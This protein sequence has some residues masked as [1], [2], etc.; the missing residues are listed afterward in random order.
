MGIGIGCD[1][2][3]TFTDLILL[4]EKTGKIEIQKVLTTP[5]D[6]SEGIETGLKHFEES[7]PKSISYSDILVHGTTLVINAVIERKGALTG[8]I[9]TKG[10]RDVLEIGRE[11]RYDG[12]DLQIRFPEPLVARSLRVEVHERMHVSG[13][14]L[15]PLEPNSVERALRN[16]LQQ[17]VE[18]IAVCLLNSYAN[19]AHEREVAQIVQ[20]IAPH[21]PVSLSSDVLREFKEY[22]RTTT[23]V[24]N[25]YATPVVSA[26]LSRFADRLRSLGFDGEL[27]MMQSSGGLGSLEA[28]RRS[29]VQIIESGPAAGVI[30]AAYYAGLTGHKTVL[31][32]DM[33]GTT[34][35]MCLVQDGRVAQNAELEIDRVH[36]FKLGSGIP[37]RIPVVDL[38]EIGAGGGSIAKVSPRGTLEVG[39]ESA[40]AFPG[41]ACYGLGGTE[42]TVSDADLVLGYLNPDYFLGSK[43]RLDRDR[44]GEAIDAGVAKPLGLSRSEAAWGIHSVVNETMASASK[45]YLAE[46]GHSPSS[47]AVVAFGGAGPVHACDLAARI[48][49]RTVVIPPRAGV[50]SA[51][52]MLISPMTRDK[53]LTYPTRTSQA[54]AIS[55]EERFRAMEQEAESELPRGADKSALRFERGLDMRYVGQG[56]ELLVP[57]RGI[58]ADGTLAASLRSAFNEIYRRLYGRVFDELELEITNLR[59]KATVPGRRFSEKDPVRTACASA[60]PALERLAY[61]PQARDFVTHKVFRRD[62][63]VAG[64]EIKG[65]AI[66]E[67]AESTTIVGANGS[68]SLHGSGAL[69]VALEPVRPAEFPALAGQ[70][71]PVSLEMLWRRLS[72]SVDELSA[73]LVCTSFSS[74]VRDVKDYACAIFDA[75]GRLIVQSTDSTPGIGGGL[76]PM[77]QHMLDKYPPE[78]LESGDVLIGNHPWY[79][80]GHHNDIFVVTPA[81]HGSTLI[82]FATCAAHH[83]DIGGRRST[84]ESRDNYEEGLKIPVSKFFRAGVPNEDIFNFI[85]ANVRLCDTVIGDLRAQLA[86]NHVACDRL[87][88]LCEERGWSDLQML[89]DV[90]VQRSRQITEAEIAKIPDGVYRHEAPIA[91]V[92]GDEIRLRVAVTIAGGEMLLDFS[93]SSPQVKRA[94]NCTLTYTSSYAQFAVRAL[95]ALPVSINQGTLAPIRITAE[96]GTI[97]NATFPAPT[98]ARTSI[99]NF[100]PEMIFSALAKAMPDRV[101]AGS[102]GTPLW[103]QYILGKKKDGTSFAPLNSAHGGLGARANQD[104]ISCLSFPVNIGNTPVEVLETEV[105]LLVRRKELWV[106]SAG[107][108]RFRGGLGQLFEMEVLDG[109]IGPDGPLLVGFRGGR[110]VHPVPGLL[111]GGNGP[112]G[113]LIINGEDAQ[114]GGDASVEP[115]QTVLCQVPGGGGLGDPG[116][117]D[118]ELIRRDLAYGYITP[119]HARAAYGYVEEQSAAA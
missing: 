115:G 100:V 66:I 99:G 40:S 2:G 42:P 20:R 62:A 33:G 47:C 58:A 93:G 46:K 27:L 71:D 5:S 101:V 78:R 9:T 59:V 74:V 50:A 97:L 22:E 36:R 43:M 70:L 32:F 35:K 81:F 112:N 111:G 75:R 69:V 119:D 96:Q 65:P 44:A 7:E 85:A 86:A 6:P 57:V 48:G 39:P 18:S 98:F 64:M 21:I 94:I 107:P 19:P 8:L 116:E 34:A 26:Y 73:A 118:P 45:V 16:L 15:I 72:S 54:E 76:H 51:Y 29:P 88:E 60:P 82:G 38:M 95:L 13:R 83:V 105:P 103:A 3:G 56:Y 79:G 63:V 92:D 53:V 28:A 1:I 102:G 10:F 89:A 49:A 37:V 30:G 80:S 106:D 84:T 117:R 55:I 67:E 61:C 109:D 24:V 90:I 87:R 91:V 77:L 25:A 108:G 14:V 68:V 12:A 4:D 17:G 23:T 113:R 31:S 110:F 104:G 11:K 52:G 114:V 41:P